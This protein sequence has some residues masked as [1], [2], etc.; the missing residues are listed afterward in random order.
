MSKNYYIIPVF[1]PQ[2][3]CPHHCVFCNQEEITGQD[4]VVH[5]SDVKNIIDSYSKTI[6]KSNS[7]VE[8]SFYGGSFTGTS[9]SYQSELLKVAYDAY[10]NNTVDA[11]RLSTRPDH[12]YINREI[13]DNLKKYHV[14]TIELGVQSMDD[15][16]L[17]ESERG[18]SDTDVINASKLIKEYG[19]TLGLQ[20]MVGLPGDNESKDLYTCNEII[21]LKPDFVRIYPA[22]VL[23]NT[24]MERMY[25]EGTYHPL[26]VDEAVNICAKLYLKFYGADIPII[27]IGLQP[28]KDINVGGDIISGPFHPAIRELVESKVLNEMLDYIIS[29][30]YANANSLTIK[31]NNKSKLFS[32]KKRYYKILSSKFNNIDLNIEENK[33]LPVMSIEIDDSMSKVVLPIHDYINMVK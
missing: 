13:L 31:V 4:K 9:I 12:D 6:D 28:T 7:Y 2:V 19:F 17:K 11:I 5:P 1:V 30:K 21:K 20:M 14:K 23:K 32:C 10:M 18:H 24:A 33:N 8:I 27:R 15:S 29:S 22:L 25:N 3:G 16:V 26:T